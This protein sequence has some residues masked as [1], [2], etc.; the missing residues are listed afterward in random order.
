[1][2]AVFTSMLNGR[3]GAEVKRQIIQTVSILVQNVS[4]DTY[5][6]YLLS[7]NHINE[8]I[9]HPFDLSNEE[10]LAHYVSLLKAIALR[11]DEHTVQF[12]IGEPMAASPPVAVSPPS[13][14]SARVGGA[15][16]TAAAGVSTP[17]RAS[18]EG[19]RPS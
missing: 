15:V 8:L 9:V 3:S 10:L 4:N 5:L 12:F 13:S 2:L 1:M 7:N 6:Y 19:A 14:D 18:T 16:G 11:L 17:P